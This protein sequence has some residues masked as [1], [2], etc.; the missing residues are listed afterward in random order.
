MSDYRPLLD[1][2]NY[3]PHYDASSDNSDGPTLP[4]IHE[5]NRPIVEKRLLRKLDL[6]VAFLVLIYIINCRTWPSKSL[7]VARL[8]RPLASAARLRGLEEDLNMTGNQF[9]TL[10]SVLYLGYVIMQAP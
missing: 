7:G 4:Y 5:E 6:R 8:N 2:S 9:N 3:N 1:A 10:I